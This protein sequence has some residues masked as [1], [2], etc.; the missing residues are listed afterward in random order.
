MGKSSKPAAGLAESYTLLKYAQDVE[1]IRRELKADRLHLFGHSFGGIVAMQYAVLYAEHVESLIFFGGGPPTWEGIQTCNQ[2]MIVRV[3]ALIQTGVIP[4]MD[5]WTG[6]GTDPILPAY[7][8]DPSFTFSEDSRGGPPQHDQ[9]VSDLTYRNMVDMDLRAAL[10]S[11]QKRVLLMIGKDDPFGLE[12]A[13]A[14]RGA[15]THSTVDYVVIDQCGHFW[16]ECPQAFY[17]RVQEFLKK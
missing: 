17:S 16:H 7:F 3:Q 1:A 4:P 8:S 13:E 15:L 14:V 2:N 6:K 11:L 10:A 12:M 9:T 5:Q